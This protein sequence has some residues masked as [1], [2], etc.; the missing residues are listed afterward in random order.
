VVLTGQLQSNA[1]PCYAQRQ[2]LMLD[3]TLIANSRATFTEL[4]PYLWTGS[5]PEYDAFASSFLAVLDRQKFFDDRDRAGLVAADSP[6]NRAV[7]DDIVAP[8]LTALGIEG[9]VAWIDTTDL[10]TL[11]TGLTQAAV[12]FRGKEIDR[13][14][15]LGGARIA[16]FFMTS[17]AAQSYTARYGI[18]TFDSPSFMVANPGTIPPEA[19]KG[20][21]G[22]GFAPGYDVPDS[23]LAF[24]DTDAEKRCQ[25][26]YADA[27]ITFRQRENARVAFTY[28]DAGLLLQAAAADLGPNLNATAWGA[29]AQALGTS[30][31]TATGFG[32][33]LGADRYA[34][35]TGYR[36][37]KYDTG[38]SCFA[39]EG[40]VTPL[41]E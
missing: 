30:F 1:R 34:A 20:M 13:V 4:A 33:E 27:G 7:Y 2:T 21:V 5:F 32:G 22:I 15:F 38:C 35:G 31:A 36:V 23:R 25:K 9:T 8:A 17:A 40:P 18:S 10:G 12:S 41:G 3:A 11:N 39:Y 6:A 19:L 16:P 26:I 37:L 24:P 29:A 14:F 28:C